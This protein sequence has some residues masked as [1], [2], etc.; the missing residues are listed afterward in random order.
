M[1]APAPRGSS[2]APST[3]RA[4]RGAP[5]SR[6]EPAAWCSR[7][8]PASMSAAAPSSRAPGTATSPPAAS[9]SATVFTGSGGRPVDGG[10]AF[11]TSTDTLVRLQS[12][13]LRDR[14]LISNSL[15]FPLCSA[16][17]ASR[18]IPGTRGTSATSARSSSASTAAGA[19]S[20]RAPAGPCTCSITPTRSWVWTRAWNGAR[21]R[22]PPRSRASRTTVPSSRNRFARCTRTRPT[23]RARAATARSRW[24]R[25]AATS[26]ARKRRSPTS[27]ARSPTGR[28]STTGRSSRCSRRRRWRPSVPGSHASGALRRSRIAPAWRSGISS[29]AP[30][31]RFPSGPAGGSRAAGSSGSRRD[32]C[33]TPAAGASRSPCTTTPRSGRWRRSRIA[34]LPPTRAAPEP[35]RRAARRPRAT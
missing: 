12:L 28:S 29:G 10:F 9:D 16:P 18:S 7:T 5:R 27:S 14:L 24:S 2:R 13:R 25:R 31:C 22:S 6:R 1:T 32:A 4:S 20:R 21:S 3:C 33:A 17:P 11:A 8:A 15:A 23:P 19:R 26:G 34:T 35:W 30:G